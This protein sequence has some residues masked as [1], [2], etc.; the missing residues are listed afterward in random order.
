MKSDMWF[1]QESVLLSILLVAGLGIIGL[2]L[3]EILLM[4]RQLKI[5]M[6]TKSRVKRQPGQAKK[7]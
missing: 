2:L 6:G 4:R 1:F 7:N 5:E 3:R